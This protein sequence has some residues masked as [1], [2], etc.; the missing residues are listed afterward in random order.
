MKRAKLRV[1]CSKKCRKLGGL[2]LLARLGELLAEVPELKL[3]PVG[4]LKRCQRGCVAV[5]KGKKTKVWKDHTPE[6]AAELAA[7]VRQRLLK[8]QEAG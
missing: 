4:C 3:E 2:L 8:W 7:K 6:D 1:C 5:L